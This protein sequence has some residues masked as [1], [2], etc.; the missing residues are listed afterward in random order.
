MGMGRAGAR[1]LDEALALAARVDHT[2]G[3]T[4]RGLMGYEGHCADIPDPGLRAAET[5]RALK[6]V[7]AVADAVEC[8]DCRSMLFLR[9]PR[10]PI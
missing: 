9:V 10:E 7:P 8:E 6:R 2:S 4:L 3:L 5:E 1:S